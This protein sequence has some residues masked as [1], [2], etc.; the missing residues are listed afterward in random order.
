VTSE[1]LDPM[2]TKGNGGCSNLK[3]YDFTVQMMSNLESLFHLILKVLTS[4]VGLT[5]EIYP[6]L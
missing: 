6:G 5:T 2:F 4:V 3:L 1:R